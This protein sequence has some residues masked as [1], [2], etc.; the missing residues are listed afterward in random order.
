MVVT[1]SGQ[2]GP[3][4]D[5]EPPSRRSG[6]RVLLAVV[7]IL[8]LVSLIVAI[9]VPVSNSVAEPRQ[10][11]GPST[12]VVLTDL[13][14][15]EDAETTTTAPSTSDSA[16]TTETT[17]S[18]TTRTTSRSRTTTATTRPPASTSTTRVTGPIVYPGG[19]CLTPGDKGVSS[20]GRAMVCRHQQGAIINQW[21]Y[22]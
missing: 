16:T 14:V 1:I 5:G 9:R 13:M 6:R 7:A 22:A 3:P 8:G 19:L 11:A 21:G 10:P 18:T 12:R 4:E 15:P 17:T 20:D 2:L